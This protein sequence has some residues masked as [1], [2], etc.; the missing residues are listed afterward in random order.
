MQNI[1]QVFI[2][3]N[4]A[5][6][7]KFA[8]AKVAKANFRQI[9]VSWISCRRTFSYKKNFFVRRSWIFSYLR[10]F[11]SRNFWLKIPGNLNSI[12]R[13][14]KQI[15]TQFQPLTNLL[16]AT[17][18][19]KIA[20]IRC[21][22]MHAASTK[23]CNQILNVLIWDIHHLSE[24]SMLQGTTNRVNFCSILIDANIKWQNTY[25]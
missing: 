15:I 8:F 5:I 7:N 19:T 13:L 12:N 14:L 10:H 17:Y 24:I 25:E 2:C 23:T 9:P 6:P 4:V 20:F 3:S 18:A 11:C 1:K 22:K 16:R 21:F